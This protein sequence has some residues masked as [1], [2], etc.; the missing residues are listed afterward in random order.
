M[1]IKQIHH[2]Q[3]TI[4][5]DAVNDARK[6]YVELLGLTEIPKPPTLQHRGGFWL[7]IGDL[8]I[9]LGIQDNFDRYQYRGHIAYQV[10]DIAN[11]R[12]ILT[13][14]DIEI[15]ESIP[16]E[17]YERFEFRDPFG[18]RLEMIQPYPKHS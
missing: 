4:P 6:F 15:L 14:N 17:G 11:W 13:E 7:Q 5:S 1:T 9:H 12:M 8:Q 3:I 2:V 16:I 10:D 18:N